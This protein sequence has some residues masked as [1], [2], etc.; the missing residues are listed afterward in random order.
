MFTILDEQ[1]S[2]TA[3]WKI[4]ADMSYFYLQRRTISMNLSEEVAETMEFMLHRMHV[5]YVLHPGCN[6]V[7]LVN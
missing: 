6:F 5:F 4:S 3:R 1:T 2:I 7:L